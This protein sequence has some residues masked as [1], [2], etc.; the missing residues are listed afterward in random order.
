[1]SFLLIRRNNIWE[2][3]INQK[4]LQLTDFETSK[5]TVANNDWSGVAGVEKVFSKV[6]F[7]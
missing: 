5:N 2:S 1:M 7:S 3:V 4:L 6:H